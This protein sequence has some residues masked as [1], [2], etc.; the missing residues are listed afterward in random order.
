MNKSDWEEFY[1]VWVSTCELISGRTPTDGAVNLCFTV[2]SRFSITEI[3]RALSSHLNDPENGRYIPKPADIVRQIEGDTESRALMAWSKVEGAIRSAGAYRSVVFDE[4]EIMAAISNMGG[5]IRL[6]EMLEDEL[7]FRRNEF[8]KLYKGYVLKKPVNFPSK[9]IGLEEAHN[10]IEHTN[11][12]KPPIMIGDY[13]N[14]VKVLQADKA[15]PKQQRVFSGGMKK[16]LGKVN[17]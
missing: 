15:I 11:H 7:P 10:S 17:A 8:C 12:V 4:P 9:F 3:R 2:L 6:C 5:W 1:A 13:D 16:M 14:A